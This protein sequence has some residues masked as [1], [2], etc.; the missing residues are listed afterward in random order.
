MEHPHGWLSG[1]LT[2]PLCLFSA[3]HPASERSRHNAQASLPGTRLTLELTTCWQKGQ[4]TVPETSVRYA[5]KM[6]TGWGWVT[7]TDTCA[8]WALLTGGVT[9]TR[10]RG[11]KYEGW[12][13]LWWRGKRALP[14]LCERMDYGV[15][16]WRRWCCRCC[17]AGW[18]QQRKRVQLGRNY[19]IR[20]QANVNTN[21]SRLRRRIRKEKQT[22]A[23]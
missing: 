12:R 11:W 6:G 22:R 21:S 20:A 15:G 13:S 1:P 17:Q 19:G 8:A 16:V 5:G 18:I 2:A 3:P 10:H 9:P 7:T 4:E 14:T 23:E